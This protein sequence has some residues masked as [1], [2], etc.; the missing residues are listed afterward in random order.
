MAKKILLADDSL[1]IQKVV[2][3]TFSDSDYDLV[4][5]SNGLK[6]LERVWA[7]RPDLILADVVMP[8]KNGYEV[9]EVIK[10]NPATARIPVVLL[11]GTFEP[12]DRQRAERIGCDAIVSK[13]FDSQQLLSQV[14]SLLARS[15]GGATAPAAA[16]SVPSRSSPSGTEEE[17]EPEPFETGFEAEDFTGPLRVPRDP[18]RVDPFEE[19]YGSTEVDSAILAFESAHPEFAFGAEES[20]EAGRA[21]AGASRE[22]PWLAEEADAGPLE[23]AEE[24]E[25]HEALAF[26]AEPRAQMLLSE[27]FR[28]RASDAPTMELPKRLLGE[29]SLSGSAASPEEISAFDAEILFDVGAS[30]AEQ[31]GDRAA[32]SDEMASGEESASGAVEREEALFEASAGPAVKGPAPGTP[33]AGAPLDRGGAS[34]PETARELE[35]LALTASIPELTN[36]LSRVSSSGGE[37]S[38]AEIDRLASRVVAKLSDRI[39]REI[40]WEVIPDMAEIV[41]K[42]RIKELESDAE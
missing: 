3:L 14:E 11:S 12:F 7:E 32:A 2:E 25:S 23:S 39:V 28:S 35:A 17:K 6:A 24:E 40:A 9:C 38:D 21:S 5:V 10:G 18:G 33:E 16:M 29:L 37:L 13:P 30:E 22:T 36:M 4:C 41:I 31:S 19:E 26:E 20:G 1:T 34:A 8:E 15:S 27:S 42:Q